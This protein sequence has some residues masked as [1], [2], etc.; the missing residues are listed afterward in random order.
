MKDK[1]VIIG[2]IGIAVSV[3]G[4]FLATAR[5]CGCGLVKPEGAMTMEVSDVPA[6]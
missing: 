2:R 5:L 1:G 6:E 4:L 3:V